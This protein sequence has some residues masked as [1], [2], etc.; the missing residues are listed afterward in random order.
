MDHYYETTTRTCTAASTP[1]PK[2]PPASSRRPDGPPAASSARRGR[3]P[4]SSSPRTPPRRSTSSPT[5]TAGTCFRRAKAILLT[6]LEHHANLVP[7]LMLAEERGVELRYIPVGEDYLLD[8]SELD[9]LIDGVGLVGVSCMS[10]VLGTINDLGP[11]VEAAHAAGAVV[12]VDG[13]QLVPHRTVDV[14]AWGV[15]F[16]AF[17]SHKMVGPTGIG[18]AVGARGA[19][20][21]DAPVSRRWRDDPRRAPRRVRPERPP[22]EVRGRHAADRRGDR[23]AR[24]H[25]VPRV[26]GDRRRSRHTRWGSPRRRSSS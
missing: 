8:Y 18:V 23:S 12:V 19:A 20:R 16:L 14:R 22:L 6:E 1:S 5:P 11:V 17:T 24:G 7:W 13:S 3:R 21:G 9:R 10:N 26:G 4:R 2:R 15:D 25:L